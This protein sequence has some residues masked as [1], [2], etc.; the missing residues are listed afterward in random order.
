LASLNV[1][2]VGSRAFPTFAWSLLIALLGSGCLRTADSAAASSARTS[3]PRT[4]PP[5]ASAGSR[6]AGAE[7]EAHASA[8]GAEDANDRAS[9]AAYRDQSGLVPS[10]P[11]PRYPFHE[12]LPGPNLASDAPA[13]RY[14]NLSPAA[15]RTEYKKRRLPFQRD[16]RP[17]PGVA[18]ALRFTGPVHGVT[19]ATAGRSS[20]YGVLDCR[21]ALTL[22]ELAEVL[23]EHD[24]WMVIIGTAYRP[25]SRLPRSRKPSQHAHGLAADI[26]AFVLRDGRRLVVERDWSGEIGAP[27]CGPESSVKEPSEASIKLRSLVCDIARRGFFHC[28]LTPNYDAA[29]ADH[30]HFDIRRDAMRRLVR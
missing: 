29:H 9:P 23:A 25:G 11:Q 3:G 24:V 28:M 16:R 15:C 12:P 30:L 10:E 20:P 18:T 13:M 22:A 6:S 19:F 27:A 17:T 2:F 5:A 4:A 26:T 14:A 1:R 8:P 21:L 7:P